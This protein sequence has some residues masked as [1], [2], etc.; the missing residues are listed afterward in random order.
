MINHKKPPLNDKRFRKAL[1][2]AIDQQEII[3]KA[4]RGLVPL[5]PLGCC[6]RITPS[7]TP[8][9]PGIPTIPK[10][11]EKILT[12]LG[13]QK[14]ESGF[15]GKGRYKPLKLEVAGLQHH[16]CGGVHGRSGRRGPEKT[17]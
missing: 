5:H 2:Y 12:S 1:A 11:H 8:K 15:Y 6:P 13:Y 14:N 10:R 3:D 4:H 17:A 7:T 9:H 16:G